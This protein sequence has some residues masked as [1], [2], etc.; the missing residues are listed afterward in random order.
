M[1]RWLIRKRLA[2]A[3]RDLG[4][5]VDYARHILDV[6]LGAFLKF[7]KVLPLDGYRRSLPAG[8][9][10]VARLVAVRHEDC[11]PCVQIVVNQAKKEGVSPEVLQAALASEPDALPEDLADAYRFAEAVVTRSG[12]EDRLRDRIRQRHGEAGLV[13]MA[14][15]V[16]VC[17]I[18]PTVKRGL[19]YATSCSKVTVHV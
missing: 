9:Y 5:P 16:A 17:R 19:G 11:G 4:V 6:S 14:L 1:L 8:P 7:V 12:D 3:E 13:E 18:F 2:A 10:H 15:A